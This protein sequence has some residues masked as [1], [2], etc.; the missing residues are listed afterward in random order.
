MQ[1]AREDTGSPE[2]GVPGSGELPCGCWERNYGP[3]HES[4]VLHLPSSPQT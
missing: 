3:V 4:Q 2:A 1:E